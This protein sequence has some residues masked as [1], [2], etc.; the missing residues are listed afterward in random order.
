MGD[1]A[2][3]SWLGELKARESAAAEATNEPAKATA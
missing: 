2:V 1:D 3:Q